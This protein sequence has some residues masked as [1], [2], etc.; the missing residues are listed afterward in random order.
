MPEPITGRSPSPEPEVSDHTT[1]L[2]QVVDADTGGIAFTAERRDRAEEWMHR[3]TGYGRT[4]LLQSV[5]RRTRSETW[6]GE[7]TT[8]PWHS[9]CSWVGAYTEPGEPPSPVNCQRHDW[10]GKDEPVPAAFWRTRPGDGPDGG[11]P[12]G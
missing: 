5:E 12:R 4:V 11:E 2:W 7:P 1:T 3:L 10:H 6:W 9:P 8:V